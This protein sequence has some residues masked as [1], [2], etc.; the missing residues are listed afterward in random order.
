[1]QSDSP[2]QQRAIR[3][4]HCTLDLSQI[5]MMLVSISVGRLPVFL[6]RLV[7]LVMIIQLPIIAADVSSAQSR[8]SGQFDIL[9]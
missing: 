2:E 8:Y 6:R 9:L 4:G 1:M 3:I 7:E 5:R